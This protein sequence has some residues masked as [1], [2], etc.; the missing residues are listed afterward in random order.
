MGKNATNINKMSNHLS[1][2]IIEHKKKNM[3]YAAEN[4]DLGLVID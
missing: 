2:Q 4:A 1:Y 3:T